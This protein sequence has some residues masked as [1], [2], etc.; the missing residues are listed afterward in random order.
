VRDD[1]D[2]NPRAW[3]E[4]ITSDE[5]AS[6]RGSGRTPSDIQVTADGRIFLRAERDGGGDG[7]IYAL[8]YRAE[9][10]SGNRTERQ[11]IVGVPHDASRGDGQ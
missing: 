8:V 6:S 9:D 2:P 4:S 1:R 5:E 7:R 10:R 11:V 3:L